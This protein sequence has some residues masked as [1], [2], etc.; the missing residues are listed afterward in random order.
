MNQNRVRS[1]KVMIWN[2]RGIN[3]S[4]KWDSIKN[5]VLSSQCDIVCFQETKKDDFDISFLR[6][7]CPATFDSFDFL[8]TNG[9]SR[10]IL[11]AW[12]GSLFSGNRI[13]VCAYAF[14]M[15]FC[16]M[17]D[18]SKWALTCVYGPCTSEGKG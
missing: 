2:V 18:N 13:G 12:N 6:K 8:P 11:I 3:S 14:S 16:S 17:Y 1:W 7:I 5:K 4:W 9:A 10:G 15:A